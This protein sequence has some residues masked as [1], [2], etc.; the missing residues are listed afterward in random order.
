MGD[1]GGVEGD[2]GRPALRWPW[3]RIIC[4]RFLDKWWQNL[5]ET[6]GT[7]KH[8]DLGTIHEVM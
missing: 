2:D 3:F 8:V 1:A 7:D 6:I 4:D 5:D